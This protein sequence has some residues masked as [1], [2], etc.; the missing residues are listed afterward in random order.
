MNLKW[1]Y[2]SNKVTESGVYNFAGCQFALPTNLNIFNWR[3]EL[4]NYFDYEVCDLLEF[5]FPISCN[6]DNLNVICEENHKGATMFP[7]QMAKY[8]CDE[9]EAGSVVGPFSVSPFVGGHNVSPL[10]SV[11]KE[12]P[13]D[14]RVILDLS[15]PCGASVNAS[16]NKDLYLGDKINLSYPSVDD[17]VELIKVQGRGSL[18]FKRD[19]K[20]AYRQIFVDPIDIPKLGYR[21][22]GELYF[23]AGLPM[24]LR[25][26]AYICQRV[27]NSVSF[28]MLQRGYKILNYLDDFGGVETPAKASLAF[29]TLKEVLDELG[30]KESTSKACAPTTRMT[31]LGILF[32]TLKCTLEVEP[33]KLVIIKELLDIWLRKS[34]CTKK[35]LQSLLGR[36][37]FVSKCV[38]SSRIF[39]SRMLNFLRSL[40]DQVK[41]F[42]IPEDTKKDIKWWKEFIDRFNGTVMMPFQDWSSPDK[43]FAVDACLTSCGGI[44]WD[45]RQVFSCE[46]PDFIL[47]ENHPIC[48]LE[49]LTIIVAIKLWISNI[50]SKKIIIYSDSMVS[51]N[52]I[53][54]GKTRTHFMQSCLRELCFLLCT[55]E[56]ELKAVHIAGISNRIPDY[57]SRWNLDNKFQLGFWKE[58]KSYYGDFNISQVEVPFQ[59]FKF[60]NKF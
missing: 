13:E 2:L 23:D 15:F 30:L 33:K 57:L 8:L 20:R 53:N 41:V 31:F 14:R 47:S 44:N 19:L 50:K 22:N 3:F 26:S 11:P 58:I 36:L 39:L 27:T 29:S 46:F 21:W 40:N 49:L 56:C 16:I 17:L 4:S 38:R 52:L 6:F 37:Q 25:S 55:N 59:F 24:G 12:V 60:S 51:V 42:S 35:E 48:E 34:F 9:M 10:N 5:G 18:L 7:D 45:F 28:I 43:V 32:D 1:I 54:S